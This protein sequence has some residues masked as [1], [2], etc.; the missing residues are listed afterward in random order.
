MDLK[1][2]SIST[3]SKIYNQT[4]FYLMQ[5]GNFK[6]LEKKDKEKIFDIK[7][8]LDNNFKLNL[9]LISSVYFLT[10]Y[11]LIRKIKTNFLNKVLD[12]SLVSAIAYLGSYY[13][14]RK[15]IE[16]NAKEINNL[17][18]KYALMIKNTISLRNNNKNKEFNLLSIH[19]RYNYYQLNFFFLILL[20]LF[21]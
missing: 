6:E 1:K 14:Y 4:L 13:T 2:L 16:K 19:T 7:R 20:R 9:L 10:N 21:V 18:T 8:N 17:K 5:E 12:F 11:L 15:N 3:Q